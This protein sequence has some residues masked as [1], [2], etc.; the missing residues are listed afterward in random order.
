MVGASG[1]APKIVAAPG[2]RRVTILGST[3]SVGQ[4]TLDLVRRSQSLQIV[5]LTANRNVEMLARQAREFSAELAVVADPDAYNDL[6]EALAGTNIRAAA[7]APA[8]VEAACLKSDI[9][10]A[11]IVG[12]AGIEATFAALAHCSTVAIAN[13]ECLVAAG[14][15][16]FRE[17]ART[18]ATLL[19]V[20]SEHSAIFQV[21]DQ[22]QPD[23]V[24]KSTLR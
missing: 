11:S 6:V 1:V 2:E 17:A 9:V 13:K 7:G 3:G 5:A 14:A 16:F 22:S 12:A 24:A 15:L 10:M 8:L 21:L 18:G 19:P 20:D 23:A 4:S